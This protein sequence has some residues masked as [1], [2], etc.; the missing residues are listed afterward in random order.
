MARLAPVYEELR[1]GC[2]EKNRDVHRTD[3]GSISTTHVTYTIS[4]CLCTEHA[5]IQLSYTSITL[6]ISTISAFA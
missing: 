5:A 2:V 4:S 1:T 6:F 3:I